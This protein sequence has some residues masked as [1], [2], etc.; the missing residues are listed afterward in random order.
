[1]LTIARHGRAVIVG[2][3]AQFILRPE[4]TLRVRAFAPPEVRIAR[5]AERDRISRDE[6]RAVVLRHDAERNAFCR[7]HFNA[8]PSDPHHYDLLLNTGTLSVETCAD[9]VVGAFRARFPA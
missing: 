8:D 9:G 4:R 2:R 6:A 5:I 3:G 7:Q 1:M